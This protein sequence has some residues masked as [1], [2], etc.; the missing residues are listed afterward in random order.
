M[1]PYLGVR[2]ALGDKRSEFVITRHRKLNA[3]LR[4]QFKRILTRADVKPWPKLFQNLR[5]SCATELV[6]EFPPHVA[7]DWLGHNT[8]VAQ[9]HYWQAS[10]IWTSNRRLALRIQRQVHLVK[11]RGQNP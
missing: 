5:A 4:T 10:R 11:R 2:D 7:A 8:L 6:A 9:K 3:N 1:K